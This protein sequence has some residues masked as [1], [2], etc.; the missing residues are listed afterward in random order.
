MSWK[1]MQEICNFDYSV[2]H[3]VLIFATREY[4]EEK[5]KT[6][7]KHLLTHNCKCMYLVG[8][9][10]YDWYDACNAVNYEMLPDDIF[11]RIIL[12]GNPE[13]IAQPYSRLMERFEYAVAHVHGEPVEKLYLTYE[14]EDGI[15]E[16]AELEPFS[17]D[18]NADISA[19]ILRTW[20]LGSAR[21][22]FQM[23]PL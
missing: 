2:P 12:Y 9:Y 11:S 18:P 4:P 5:M 1:F 6:I 7:C 21:Q 10:A 23:Q 22:R 8:P 17:T 16:I 14:A 3:A 15:P 19:E 20:S 13:E